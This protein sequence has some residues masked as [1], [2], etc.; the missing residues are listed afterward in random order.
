VTRTKKYKDTPGK[1]A[2]DG[3]KDGR[4]LASSD[5]H[6]RKPG[7]QRQYDRDALI[8]LICEQIADG[9]GLR[10]VLREMEGGPTVGAFLLWVSEDPAAADRYARARSMCLDAMAEDILDIADTARIGQKSVSKATGL[11]IT[12]GDMVERSRLQVEA[13]KW[14]MA[15]LAPQKYG[16]RRHVEHSGSIGL[17]SLVAGDDADA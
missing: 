5:A 4:A 11:E 16:E 2:P 12:E 1:D 8:P 14:L 9:K 10:T 7:G 13:R 6:P 3:V 15:K 17:E